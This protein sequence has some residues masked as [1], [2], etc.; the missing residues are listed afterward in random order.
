[1]A[2]GRTRSRPLAPP[3]RD[4]R[5]HQQAP[6]A[7]LQPRAAPS[8]RPHRPPSLPPGLA[9]LL[10]RKFPIVDSQTASAV[11]A[12]RR[13]RFSP[14]PTLNPQTH[15]ATGEF[16]IADSKRLAGH[17]LDS[18]V[19]ALPPGGEQFLGVFD[20]RGFELRNADIQFAAFLVDAFFEY[21]PRR[22]GAPCPGA[23]QGRRR[24]GHGGAAGAPVCCI[25]PEQGAA[26]FCLPYLPACGRRQGHLPI[27][28]RMP[29]HLTPPR[30]PLNPP[31]Q[32]GAGADGG[33]ALGVPPLLGAHQAAVSAPPP[34]ARP[35]PPASC[36]ACRAWLLSSDPSRAACVAGAGDAC[37]AAEPAFCASCGRQYPVILAAP[38]PPP[39]TPSGCASTRRWCASW[40]APRCRTTSRQT[41]CRQTSGPKVSNAAPRRG[42]ARNGGTCARLAAGRLQV[43]TRPNLSGL[44]SLHPFL[45]TFLPPP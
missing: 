13:R 41:R 16:P 24:G 15:F 11:A 37:A 2:R 27:R 14:L 7:C 21:Y 18:A 12:C 17:I 25:C 35:A 4:P 26:S 36:S 20:L 28:P 39:P 1:M 38:C 45:P 40:T 8:P 10:L 23:G 32:G 44:R 33:R 31:E 30:H 34:F 3:R 9:A 19:A 6:C 5:H 22:C 42:C 29:R 43:V